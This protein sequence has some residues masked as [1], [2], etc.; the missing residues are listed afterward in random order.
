MLTDPQRRFLDVERVAR[1]ATV[2][3][4]GQPHVVP[5]CYAIVD[6]KIG[7]TVDEKPKRGD[8]ELKRLSNIRANPKVAMTDR[9]DEDWS[10]LGWVM[11]QGRAEILT[12]GHKWK[13]LQAK[14][15]ERYSQLREMQIENLPS[16]VITIQ[17]V[18]S[19]GQL[20]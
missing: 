17:K 11:L 16:V 7:F 3:S 9:Y 1:L 13:V 10:K 20:D 14:L 5:I 2:G 12:S 15:R 4:D 19:W 8:K 18:M 6:D